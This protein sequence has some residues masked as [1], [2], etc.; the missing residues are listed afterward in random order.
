[1]SFI[2]KYIS[3]TCI[4]YSFGTKIDKNISDMV[5]KVYRFLP[6]YIELH[7]AGIID[8]VPSYT[9]LAIHFNTSCELLKD[10]HA[11]DDSITK[12]L[13]ETYS[14]KPVEHTIYV[15]YSGEDID[16]VC[17]KLKLSMDEFIDLH[18]ASYSIAMI[19]FREHFPYLLG[20]DERLDIPRRDA[21]RTNVKKG[22][23]AIAAG[24][25]G[26]YPEDSPGGWHIIGHTD[27]DD[28]KT[29]RPSDIIIFKNKDAHAH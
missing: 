6:R 19:G 1:M 25:T 29:L 5:L 11:Y 24:Q 28:F 2:S 16:E 17:K 21:P 3:A 15:D 14:D 27:F 23:V 13:D 18:T 7:K 26:V 12:A 10:P 9:A 8:I 4:E 20:L 22:S